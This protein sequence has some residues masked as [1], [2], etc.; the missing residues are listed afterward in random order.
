[1]DWDAG[2]NNPRSYDMVQLDDWENQIVYDVNQPFVL[3][4][5]PR[6]VLSR[7]SHSLCSVISSSFSPPAK[8]TRP[9]ALTPFNKQIEEGDWVQ[10]IIWDSTKPARP[11]FL[12]TVV[13]E[14]DEN[15][16]SPSSFLPRR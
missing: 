11:S 12:G 10:G 2:V 15:S 16:E 6:S 13:E 1:M 4:H 5:P 8:R 9:N 14:Q 7:L 3:S